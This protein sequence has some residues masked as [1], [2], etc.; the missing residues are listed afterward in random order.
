MPEAS[1]WLSGL[2]LGTCVWCYLVDTFRLA[3][4]TCDVYADVVSFVLCW[5][6]GAEVLGRDS[7]VLV[8]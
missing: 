7:L 2:T 8:A 6:V 5:M 1:W 4:L 3:V